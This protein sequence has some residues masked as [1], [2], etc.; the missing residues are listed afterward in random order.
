MHH[1]INKPQWQVKPGALWA[2]CR[3]SDGAHESM[4]EPKCQNQVLHTNCVTFWVWLWYTFSETIDLLDKLWIRVI[5]LLL[6]ALSTSEKSNQEVFILQLHILLSDVPTSPTFL[7]KKCRLSWSYQNETLL[8]LSFLLGDFSFSPHSPHPQLVEG[9]MDDLLHMHRCSCQLS[10]PSFHPR[11]SV[12]GH[13][14]VTVHVY[15]YDC[16][17]GYHFTAASMAAASC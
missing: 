12:M 15:V 8:P 9:L 10:G 13:S 16:D 6:E 14:S 3:F 1:Q 11:S 2:R 5:L 17:S 7:P 4:A